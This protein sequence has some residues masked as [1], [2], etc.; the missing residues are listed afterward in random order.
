LKPEVHNILDRLSR[1]L[2]N[3]LPGSTAHKNMAPPERLLE[4]PP[5]NTN[6]NQA[7]VLLLLFIEDGTLKTVFIRRPAS[8]KNH[9]GQIAFPG[10]KSEIID[11]DLS[12]TALREAAEEIGINTDQV[13]IIGQLSP[14]YV[15]ISNFSIETFIGWSHRIPSF[16][17]DT[18]YEAK[19]YA[20]YYSPA[21]GMFYVQRNEQVGDYPW[22]DVFVNMKIK[23]T[24][25][26]VKYSNLGATILKSGY[27][28]TPNYAAQPA[29]LGFGLSWTFYD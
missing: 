24:R 28:T 16:G 23:R 7:G 27:Y 12:E 4:P 20:D 25:F 21:L 10:G 9:A 11:K 14:I 1:E 8:M 3:P 17:L 6:I 13:E 22:M 19:Y 26:Y 5:G 29:L 2:K 15:R 18:R